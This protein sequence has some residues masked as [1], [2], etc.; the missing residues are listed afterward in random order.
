[1]AL[2]HENDLTK[3]TDGDNKNELTLPIFL[4]LM[5]IYENHLAN[6]DEIVDIT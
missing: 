5:I 4:L 3:K 6:K 2:L 1:M